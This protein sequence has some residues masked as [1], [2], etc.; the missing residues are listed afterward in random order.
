M[1]PPARRQRTTYDM[2]PQRELTLEEIEEQ[3]DQSCEPSLA[4]TSPTDTPAEHPEFPGQAR[5]A[6]LPGQA[7]I[8]IDE[9][10]PNQGPP[11]MATAPSTPADAV[12]CTSS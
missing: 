7:V 2:A 8:A 6:A 9:A 10:D 3:M 1:Q 4:P 5:P 12:R 11:T